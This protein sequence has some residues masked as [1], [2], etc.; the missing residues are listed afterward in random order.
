MRSSAV[1]LLRYELWNLLRARWLIPYT[2]IFGGLAT[3]LLRFSS[4]PTK[5]ALSLQSVVLLIL[6]LV[7]AL[8]S[9]VYWYNSESFTSL[10]LTQPLRR[11]SVFL[12]RWGA[13]SIGLSACFTLGVGTAF[14]S[15]GY[16]GKEACT[17]LGAGLALTMAF[18]ALGMLIA[19]TVEDRMK[20][21]G[22]TLVLWLY[23]ALLHD[24][25]VFLLLANFADYPVEVPGLLLL[26]SNPID[27]ARLALLLSF[28]LSAMMG[29]TG[30]ILQKMLSGPAG[31]SFASAMLLVWIAIPLGLGLRRFAK[32]NL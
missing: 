25:V 18:S 19:V 7:S 12:A 11:S 26:M 30:R 15:A 22:A 21:I 27:L 3:A 29:Y 20:G 1:F 32:K 28:D 6:P 17:L 5:A 8:Y 16:L 31:I 10:L 24:A 14:A 13:I 23:C 9:C 2:L 4:D